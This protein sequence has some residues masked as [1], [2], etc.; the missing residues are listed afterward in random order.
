MVPSDRPLPEKSKAHTSHP[1]LRKYFATGNAYN[2]FEPK[3][4]AYTMH[5]SDRS[6]FSSSTS[7]LC[8]RA[9]GIRI[10]TVD[11]SGSVISNSYNES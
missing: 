9:L 11:M 1:C 7:R 5:L 4:C 10:V 3:P 6:R 2:L 8:P